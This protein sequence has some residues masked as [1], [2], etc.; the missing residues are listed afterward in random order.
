MASLDV[1]NTIDLTQEDQVLFGDFMAWI[2]NY[3][4]YI[5]NQW[6]EK[7]NSHMEDDDIDVVDG[8]VNIELDDEDAA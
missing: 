4:S 8:L 6:A 5:I 3:N 2:D 1:S 7:A